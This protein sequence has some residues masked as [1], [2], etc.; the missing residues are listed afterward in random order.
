MGITTEKKL[1]FG[2][3][4]LPL[5]ERDNVKSIDLA[6]FREMADRFLERGFCYFDTAYPYHD[7]C[8]EEAIR[9]CVVER[10]PRERFWL[11]DKMPIFLVTAP[12]DYERFFAEQLRRCGVSYFD[13][14]LLHNLG[15]DRY[16]ETQRFGGFDFLKR[17]KERGLARNVG[18]SF[19]D[20]AETLD[21]ILTEHPEVDV[22]QLQINY[23][24]WDGAVA[25]SGRCYETAV[26]HGKEV[27]VME[28][29]KGGQLA[30]LPDAAQRLFTEFYGAG[31]PSPASLA[32]R[33]AASL[34]QVRV[35]LSGMSTAA[36]LDDNTGYMQDCRPLSDDER[37]LTVRIAQEL[38]RAIR[39]PCT[40]CRYCM[41]VCPQNIAIPDY[42]G[43][44]N[45]HAVTGHKTN[46]YYQRYSLH[47]GKAS[48][49]LKCGLCE[50][51][52]PQHIQIR[53]FLE[54]FAALY[55]G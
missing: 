50:T 10:Y 54:E 48:E 39:V 26:R 18:F 41:E 17:L 6:Q 45:L 40:S 30:N 13:V 20:D 29:V 19:H 7:G 1:G 5:T 24:D 38:R 8:S 4:R 9:K 16:P 23:L 36:Q 31:A 49:C 34:E 52:C 12:E 2:A 44:L 28:P 43:L 32:I 11:A 46:M 37:A 47:H 55:E 21:R 3:M 42:F 22:V 27:I 14:Y 25:Q 33:F 35:V 15:R 51:N 53:D